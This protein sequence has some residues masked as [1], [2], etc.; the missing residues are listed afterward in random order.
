VLD[1]IIDTAQLFL[2]DEELSPVEPQLRE[3]GAAHVAFSPRDLRG[4]VR[5][6]RR[7]L[8]RAPQPALTLEESILA[9]LPWPAAST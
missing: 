3:T 2:A 4:A 8:A 6:I 5:L 9:R 7:H 1:R